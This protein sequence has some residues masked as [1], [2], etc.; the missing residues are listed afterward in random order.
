MTDWTVTPSGTF[1]F[2]GQALRAALGK[3]GV[4]AESDKREGDKATPIGRWPVRR[5]LYRPDRGEAPVTDLPVRAIRADDG[6]CDAPEDAAYNRPVRLPYPA[7]AESMMREDGLYDVVVILGHND[8]PPVSGAGSAIFLHCARPD[9]GPT[10]GCVALA[11]TELLEVL[12]A[13]KPG[14]TLGVVAD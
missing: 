10:L 14:D 11:K 4:I 9:Y 1:D 7:S 8:D 3:S 13:M 5:V 6:W 2:N 12:K